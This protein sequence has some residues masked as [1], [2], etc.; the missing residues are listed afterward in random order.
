M[1]VSVSLKLWLGSPFHT[2]SKLNIARKVRG[3]QR[4]V[5]HIKLEPL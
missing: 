2:Q 4:I 3:Y 5:K 1:Y